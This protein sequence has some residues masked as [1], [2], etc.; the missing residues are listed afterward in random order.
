MISKKSQILTKIVSILETL[1]PND[2]KTVNYQIIKIADGD[3]EEWELPAIQ[4]IDQGEIV[5]HEQG[6]ARKTWDL[7]LEILLKTTVE[8]QVN[9]QTMFDLQNLIERTL[10]E[11][12]QIG[13]PGVIDLKYNGSQSDLHLL[14][15]LYYC[16]MDFT[17]RYYD[18][19]VSTC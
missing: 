1:I 7:V 5:E 12:P 10:W 9:Q 2:I 6:R 4:L 16:R 11:N 8:G 17:V 15:P 14:S 3:F 19:L 13:I 18:A